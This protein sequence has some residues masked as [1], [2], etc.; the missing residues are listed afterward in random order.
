MTCRIRVRSRSSVR[1][2]IVG[3]SVDGWGVGL[4]R[5]GA[6]LILQMDAATSL[7]IIRARGRATDDHDIRSPN[8]HTRKWYNSK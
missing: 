4:C 6:N 1:E 5:T 8:H 3:G 7:H 2:R